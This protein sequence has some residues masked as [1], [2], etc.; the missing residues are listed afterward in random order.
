LEADADNSIIFFF[1]EGIEFK[2]I[3]IIDAGKSS[4]YASLP[5]AST[6]R[7]PRP[8]RQRVRHHLARQQDLQHPDNPRVPVLAEHHPDIG[9]LARK[10]E[11]I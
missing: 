3:N 5:T 10:S 1:N 6:T 4:S 8:R 9:K 11:V 2:H 7:S